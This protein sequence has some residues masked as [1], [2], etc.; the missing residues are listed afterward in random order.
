[1]LFEY[2]P[3]L[4]IVSWLNKVFTD[5]QNG[6]SLLRWLW[7]WCKASPLKNLTYSYAI[8][9][10]VAPQYDL[11]WSEAFSQWRTSGYWNPGDR[12]RSMLKFPNKD[13]SNLFTFIRSLLT[14]SRGDLFLRSKKPMNVISFWQKFRFIRLV[15]FWHRRIFASRE[16]CGFSALTFFAKELML[17]LLL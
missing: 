6:V 5:V 15:V 3:V 1:M 13:L 12:R 4:L 7:W 9:V 11:Y 10:K 17:L 14:L 8:N 16:G 2:K